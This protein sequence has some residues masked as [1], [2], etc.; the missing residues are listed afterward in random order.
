M[1]RGTVKV[2]ATDKIAAL[3]QQ[4]KEL[5][6]KEVLVGITED[7]AARQG[8]DKINNAELLYVHTHGVRQPAMRKE[9]KQNIDGGM[10]Y[11]EAHSLYLRTHGSPLMQVPPRPVIE[12]AIEDKKEEIARQLGAAS[13]AALDGAPALAQAAMEKA[14]MMGA[15]AAQDWFE[16]PKNNWPPLAEATLRKREKKGNRRDDAVP[17]VD[18]NQMRKAITYV[19]RDKA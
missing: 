15:T 10:K 12:P 2:S 19:V 13:K 16:N 11:S 1:V 8:D 7:K 3:Q 5:A 17:L 6:R 18:T 14:G 9:M 4:L